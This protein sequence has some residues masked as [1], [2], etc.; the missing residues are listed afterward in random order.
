MRLFCLSF[1]IFISSACLAQS[2]LNLEKAGRLA[3][4]PLKCLAKEYPNKL[5]QTL[6]SGEQLKSPA[7]LHPAFYGCFDWHS[8]VHGHWSL[9][10]LLDKFPTLASK[11]TII[12][13]LQTNL[14]AGNIGAEI[15]YFN[16]KVEKSFE[17][18]YGWAW[19]LKLQQALDQ[20][21]QPYAV[22][23]AHNLQPLTDLLCKR[24]IEFL[25]K[26]VYPLRVGTHTNTAFGLSLAYEYAL[27]AENT[28]LKLA[29][30]SA[31]RRFFIKD[32]NC[33]FA[34]EPSGSDFLS[35]CLE[36]I[37]LMDMVLAKKEF[38][39]W[40]KGFAPHLSDK[41]FNLPVAVVGD[42]EDG[43][44]VHL[45]GLNF[46]RAWCFYALAKKYPQQFGHLRSLADKHLQYSL[47]SITDGNYEGEHWLASFALRAFEAR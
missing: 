24:Y 30:D 34:W 3:T 10:F 46:S 16:Q 22:N 11:D 33:P 1:T 40:V 43:Q 38:L 21:K 26:L 6:A 18:T 29:I 25:P 44:L 45:D 23:L 28:K 13:L 42:R 41:N 31:A 4:L 7:A 47:P 15:D 5:N 37:N 8:S 27:H 36:E 12:K 32:K 20:S 35:P 2:T 17:R 19:L 14:S 9:V 39:I